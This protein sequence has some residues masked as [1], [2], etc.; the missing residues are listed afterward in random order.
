MHELV[1]HLAARRRSRSASARSAACAAAEPRVA[2]PQAERR[3]ARPTPSPTSSAGRCA[4]HRARRATRA[5]LSTVSG[6]CSVKRCS[7]K[8][9]VRAALAARAVVGH[10]HHD[11][12]VED[13]EL[14]ELVDHAPDLRVG[15][16]EE[17]GVHL[18]LAR[19]ARRVSS[20]RG[21]PT[22]RSSSGAGVSVGAGG[23][24]ARLDLP[25]EHLVAPA[26]PSPRRTRRGTRSTH[27][28]ATWCGACIAPSA[29]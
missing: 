26:R 21:G 2:L 22:R 10:E 3:V 19:A 23:H 6:T 27:S 11:G 20:A 15:V 1:A 25:G 18:H 7:L 9:P 12:V 14:L 29:K 4:R 17:A 5:L 28:G 8:V 16:R 24:D 13:A